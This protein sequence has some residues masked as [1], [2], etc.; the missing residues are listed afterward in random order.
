VETAAL[1]HA[2]TLEEV[3]TPHGLHYIQQGKDLSDVDNL[4]ITGGAVIHNKNA[5]KIASF[6]LSTPSK[7]FSLLPKRAKV[8]VDQK[9]I[10]SAMGLLSAEYPEAAYTIM[11]K[12]LVDHGTYEQTTL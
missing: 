1:R 12:E 3:Y 8:Y 6:A 11:K 5:G 7:P 2:G 10:L 9:Y 4:I